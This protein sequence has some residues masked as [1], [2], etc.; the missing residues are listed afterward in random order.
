MPTQPS[1]RILL[2][3]TLLAFAP[4][5]AQAKGGAVSIGQTNPGTLDIN[6]TIDPQ[7]VAPRGGATTTTML[8]VA[9]IPAASPTVKAKFFGKG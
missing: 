9:V 8:D 5:S 4:V 1:P 7:S 3:V 2:I 6:R